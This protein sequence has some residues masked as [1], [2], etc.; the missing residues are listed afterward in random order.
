MSP[1][2]EAVVCS[3]KD[4]MSFFRMMGGPCNRADFVL[5]DN[6]LSNKLINTVCDAYSVAF[7]ICVG[8]SLGGLFV[9]LVELVDLC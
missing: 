4:F 2:F 6:S 1:S 5:F 8:V 9:L 3:K 7:L